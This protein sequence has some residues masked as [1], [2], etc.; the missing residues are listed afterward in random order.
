MLQSPLFNKWISQLIILTLKQNQAAV[1]E[2]QTIRVISTNIQIHRMQTNQQKTNF[3]N[4]LPNQYVLLEKSRIQLVKLLHSQTYHQS[5]EKYLELIRGSD[6][7]ATS[8]T[9][10]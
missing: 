7:Q 9:Q 8:F 2:A 4:H 5:L 6:T 1:I 10:R 3:R